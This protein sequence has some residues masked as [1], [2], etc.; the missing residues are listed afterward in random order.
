[1]FV[2]LRI[3]RRKR[4]IQILCWLV[5]VRRRI[6]FRIVSRNY[7][8]WPQIIIDFS[9]VHKSESEMGSSR[10]LEYHRTLDA[11]IWRRQNEHS[12][13]PC[14]FPVS[15]LLFLIIVNHSITPS[16]RKIDSFTVN[17]RSHSSKSWRIEWW[18]LS[19]SILDLYSENSRNNTDFSKIDISWLSTLHP[20]E[21]I[22][23]ESR[24]KY[25]TS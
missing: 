13:I 16:H 17:P 15:L 21:H 19:L 12:S 1:M 14:L 10:I 7:A 24:S 22:I 6:Y 3:R 4:W 8:P 23:C 2:N 11:W 18:A 9:V 5:W 20:I 25:N